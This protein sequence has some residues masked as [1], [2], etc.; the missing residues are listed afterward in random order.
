M[1]SPTLQKCCIMHAK[2]MVETN[3]F[4]SIQL[5][6]KVIVGVCNYVIFLAIFLD[7]T[8]IVCRDDIVSTKRSFSKVLVWNHQDKCSMKKLRQHDKMV[9]CCNFRVVEDDLKLFCDVY[10]ILC[11]VSDPNLGGAGADCFH[12]E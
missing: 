12:P 5:K 3:C 10:I 8:I 6:L 9:A 1:N 11:D 7:R 2:G 4:T